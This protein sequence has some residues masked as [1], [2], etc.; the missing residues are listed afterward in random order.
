[1]YFYDKVTHKVIHNPA[2]INTNNV[3][4]FN[5]VDVK[6]KIMNIPY[7][8]K[9]CNIS[10]FRVTQF[11]ALVC[12]LALTGC[13][14]SESLQ[15]KFNDFKYDK[16]RRILIVTLQNL[17]RGSNSKNTI[18][19]Y[20]ISF[21]SEN[22]K[23]Y[24]LTIPIIEYLDK[25]KKAIK[26]RKFKESDLIFGNLTREIVYYYCAKYLQIN[27]HGFRHLR[28]QNLIVDEQK[29]VKVVQKIAGHTNINHLDAYIELSTRNI[30]DELYG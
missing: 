20:P 29:N 2:F 16:T 12:I 21:N 25:V 30:E 27:P 17:K 14:V 23:D 9:N 26:R 11:N 1:M 6:D 19:R 4:K 13:R 3:Y 15:I 18:K 22:N 5:W 28:L 8:L 10:K 24:K 7:T